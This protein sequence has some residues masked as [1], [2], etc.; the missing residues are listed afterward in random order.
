MRTINAFVDTST[1]NRILRI[2]EKQPNNQKWEEDREYLPK[3]MEYVEK[4][5]VQ[6]FV[7]PSVKQEI[8]ATP[9]SQKRER[10]LALFNQYHYT[11][12]NKTI[13]GRTRGVKSP[14]FTFPATF[15][16][17]EEGKELEEL[18]KEIKGFEQDE[19]I[20]LD[21]VSNSKVEVLLT[22]DRKHLATQ[23]IW[24]YL[25]SKSLDK[26]MLVCTPKQFYEHLQ[27]V[28]N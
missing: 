23:E 27:K 10:L 11:P 18:C 3:V 15:V 17:N 1:L 26:K 20:F 24:D 5:I 22:T 12:Y 19:K 9:D 7:N 28:G 6:L 14:S 21:A 25:K 13:W 16:T 8:E 4:G 2:E